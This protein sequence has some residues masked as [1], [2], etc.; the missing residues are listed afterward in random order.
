MRKA[1]TQLQMLSQTAEISNQG[2]RELTVEH[3]NKMTKLQGI[4]SMRDSAEI[5]KKIINTESTDEF[6]KIVDDT[7]Q[8]NMDTEELADQLY[9][10]M[11]SNEVTDQ[12]R[13]QVSLEY[14]K[15]GLAI[16]RRCQ[17]SLA[18]QKFLIGLRTIAW[19]KQ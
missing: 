16:A 15:F 12:V 1:V 18:L 9:N 17:E 3:M 8:R 13:Q 2:I 10:I 5:L 7:L 11:L 4:V 19:V 14:A 6:M